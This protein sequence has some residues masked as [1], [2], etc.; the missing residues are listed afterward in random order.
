[1]DACRHCDHWGNRV[2][3]YLIRFQGHLFGMRKMWASHSYWTPVHF[4]ESIFGTQIMPDLLAELM[5][6][7][8]IRLPQ[9]W[10]P[11]MQYIYDSRIDDVI[12]NRRQFVTNTLLAYVSCIDICQIIAEYSVGAAIPLLDELSLPG[13]TKEWLNNCIMS[14]P[15]PV[16][17]TIFQ[18]VCDSSSKRVCLTYDHNDWWCVDSIIRRMNDSNKGMSLPGEPDLVCDVDSSCQ[19]VCDSPQCFSTQSICLI[20]WHTQV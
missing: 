19:V 7:S 14:K 1:M 5:V 2:N 17:K 18:L 11:L 12:K 6:A 4:L 10:L 8:D 9:L 15:Y 13:P 16:T 3:H 20:D